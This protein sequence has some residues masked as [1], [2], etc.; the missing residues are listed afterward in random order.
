MKNPSDMSSPD[1]DEHDDPTFGHEEHGDQEH[2]GEQ[3]AGLPR[4]SISE[5]RPTQMTIGKLQTNMKACLWGLEDK[6]NSH[7]I[8]TAIGKH[9]VPVVRGA[10][11]NG[12]KKYY[13]IDNHHFVYALYKAKHPDPVE[14]YIRIVANLSKLDRDDFWYVLDA[15]GWSHRYDENGQRCEDYEKIPKRIEEMKD[16]RFRSL[17]GALRRAGGFAKDTTP[18]SEFQWANFLRRELQNIPSNITFDKMLHEALRLA[19]T[20]KAK[21]LPGWCGFSLRKDERVLLQTTNWT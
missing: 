6:D 16:D 8:D 19:R 3:T 21:Y 11:E 9:I 13:L 7:K 10:D 14:V 20:K 1:D 15:R 5:L 18:F 17:A 4:V 12:S 2:D